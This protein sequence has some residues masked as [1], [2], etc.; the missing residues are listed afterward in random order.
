MP[1]GVYIYMKRKITVKIIAVVAVTALMLAAAGCVTQDQPKNDDSLKKV[2]DKGE[3]VLGLDEGFPPMGFVN[4]AGEVVGFDIYVA[5]EV[6]RRL[7][8]TL[9]K[10][11]INWDTK[12][13]E[14][15]SGTIDCIW[16]GMSITPARAESMNLSE[17]YMKNEI[18]FAVMGDSD[19]KGTR[20]LKGRHVGV[21]AGSTAQEKLKETDIYPDITEVPFEENLTL[22][23]KLEAKEIDAALIDSVVAYY[24]IASSENRFFILPDSLAE[25]EYA[26]GFRK[27]DK[28]LRD[29]VQEILIE[30]KTDGTLG[31]I[32]KT[33]FGSDITTVR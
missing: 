16:N 24:F 20:D 14:L 19:I 29:K 13:D 31:R 28:A 23:Q 9:V 27:E 10:K 7:G 26:I 4:D 25:E 3:L 1:Q 33:W 12:E 8:V 21:Q 11:G 32:S 15:N 22:L 5:Q 6:C 17:P 30:M 2:L 18:I